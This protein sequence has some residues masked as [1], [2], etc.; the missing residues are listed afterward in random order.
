MGEKGFEFLGWEAT[1]DRTWNNVRR[2]QIIAIFVS[3][4]ASDI[5]NQEEEN[6]DKHQNENQP[7]HR[8]GVSK[9][10][11]NIQLTFFF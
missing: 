2:T 3:Q 5:A 10:F 1:L 4:L 8:K 6:A 7:F 11:L 9:V